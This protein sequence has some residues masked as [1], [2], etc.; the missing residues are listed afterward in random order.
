MAGKAEVKWIEKAEVLSERDME[1]ILRRI[2]VE[3]VER[4]KGLEKVILIG[5]QRRGVYLAARLRE[6]LKEME[7]VKVPRGELDI[8]LYRD[9]ISTLADQPVVHSTSVP[10]DITG[11]R[12]VLV[13]DV[14]FTGRTIR[15]ALD[16]LTDLGRPERVQLVVLVDRGHRELPIAADYVGKVIPTSRMEN[17]EVR[18]KEL[19]GEDRAVICERTGGEEH[20]VEA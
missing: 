4:N 5:I 8:T 14:L 7:N 6:I 13:D 11:K 1:R 15:A 16:A 12:V 2:A 3:I 10:G 19:D 17:V 18:V 20:G 9:D